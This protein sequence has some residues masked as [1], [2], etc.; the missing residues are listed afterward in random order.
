MGAWQ[1][2]CLCPQDRDRVSAEGTAGLTPGST[3]APKAAPPPAPQLCPALPLV[4]PIQAS[5]LKP[6]SY[7]L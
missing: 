5:I 7:S 2:L 6:H 1:L 4:T 3:L